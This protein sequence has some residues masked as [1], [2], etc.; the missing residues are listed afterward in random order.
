MGNIVAALK[1]RIRNNG[2]V[3]CYITKFGA[4]GPYIMCEYCACTGNTCVIHREV[5]DNM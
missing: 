2:S 1:Q 5:E 3:D 4:I